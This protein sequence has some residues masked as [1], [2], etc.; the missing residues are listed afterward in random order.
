MLAESAR[1][2]QKIAN[3]RKLDYDLPFLEGAIIFSNAQLLDDPLLWPPSKDMERKFHWK[4]VG[5]FY[6]RRY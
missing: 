3:Y 5:F 6:M 1:I 2:W 4:F